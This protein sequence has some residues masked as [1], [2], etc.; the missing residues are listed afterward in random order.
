MGTIYL[1][2]PNVSNEYL[3]KNKQPTRNI[4]FNTFSTSSLITTITF[5]DS[6]RF[7]NF[8]VAVI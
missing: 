6:S 4:L 1:L 8:C 7:T 5:Y 3:Y 2:T